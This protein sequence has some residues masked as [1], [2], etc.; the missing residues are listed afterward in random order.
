MS[1]MTVAVFLG[2]MGE[3]Y[4]YENLPAMRKL[5]Q[6]QVLDHIFELA[7][8]SRLDELCMTREKLDNWAQLAW[9]LKVIAHDYNPEGRVKQM[10]VFYT[11]PLIGLV[12]AKTME[13]C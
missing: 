3:G 10:D 7:P 1:A 13:E 11:G 6:T 8:P 9:Q 4:A 12:K 5:T 2:L